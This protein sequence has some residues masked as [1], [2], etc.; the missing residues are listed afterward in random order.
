MLSAAEAL[1]FAHPFWSWA[2]LAAVFLIGE[3][4]SGSGWLLWPAAAAGLTAIVTAIW[5]LGWP[6]ETVL[7]VLCAVG[8]TYLGRRFLRNGVKTPGADINDPAMRLIGQRG[9]A[10]GAFE[11]GCGRVFVD[12]KEWSAELE[13]GGELA[14]HARIE[15]VGVLGGARLKVKPA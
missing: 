12:G 4:I 14:A 3:M 11:Q 5:P 6:R 1:F 7:F 8:A 2:A 10:A 13:N 15:V 9:E